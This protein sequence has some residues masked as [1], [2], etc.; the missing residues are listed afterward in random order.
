[1]NQYSSCLHV[2][3]ITILKKMYRVS[4]DKFNL[5]F[6]KLFPADKFIEHTFIDTCPSVNIINYVN[7]IE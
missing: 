4:L 5:K 6:S 1:M 7:N 2:L 3:Y